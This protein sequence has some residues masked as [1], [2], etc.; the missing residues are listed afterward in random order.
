[1]LIY[2]VI[3][4]FSLFINVNAGVCISKG[5]R[6]LDSAHSNF[7]PSSK[8]EKIPQSQKKSV[9]AK[10][11]KDLVEHIKKRISRDIQIK[12]KFL[13]IELFKADLDLLKESHP[14]YSD[15]NCTEYLEL[16]HSAN[17]G[18]L[19]LSKELK[20]QIAD[21][22]NQYINDSGYPEDIVKSVFI[23]ELKFFEA[24]PESIKKIFEETQELLSLQ[25]MNLTNSI[26]EVTEVIEDHLLILFRNYGIDPVYRFP[27]RQEEKN[28]R[29]L[30]KGYLPIPQCMEDEIISF[31]YNGILL[32]SKEKYLAA[33]ES[34]FRKNL[35]DPKSLENIKSLLKE[36]EYSEQTITESAFQLYDG[37]K[38]SIWAE[39]ELSE[40]ESWG[41]S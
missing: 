10:D 13:I 30:N 33:L 27:M 15:L 20:Q 37:T 41:L 4:F 23:E 31:M 22:Y 12:L 5:I 19:P 35:I 8:L 32:D 9:L 16:V 28:K 36:L 7:R 17:K 21:Y 18:F 1:M 25:S 29:M 11:L 2:L 6:P 14:K 39:E 38:A 24:H 40:E 3:M 34:F 26:T